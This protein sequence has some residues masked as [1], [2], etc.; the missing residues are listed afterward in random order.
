MH[1]LN[2]ADGRPL[3]HLR[4]MGKQQIGHCLHLP[5][6]E[7]AAV[8]RSGQVSGLVSVWQKSE[9]IGSLQKEKLRKPTGTGRINPTK[10]KHWGRFGGRKDLQPEALWLHFTGLPKLYKVSSGSSSMIDLEDVDEE[11][12]TEDESVEVEIQR[13]SIVLS[14]AENKPSVANG[15]RRLWC[16][17]P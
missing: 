3:L 16:F 12:L 15:R 14:I 5:L 1:F 7:S 6:A 17:T 11:H 9:C 4:R 2:Q 8:S 13:M 10:E